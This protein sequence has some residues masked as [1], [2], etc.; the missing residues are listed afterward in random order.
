VHRDGQGNTKIQVVVD[1]PYTAGSFRSK[2]YECFFQWAEHLNNYHPNVIAV[3]FQINGY[4]PIRYQT[5][6]YD[7]RVS[8]LNIFS[9]EECQFLQDYQRLR[10]SPERFRPKELFSEMEDNQAQEVAACK[11]QSFEIENDRIRCTDGSALQALIPYVKRLLQLY[12]AI[13]EN[14]KSA[15][16]SHE[17]RSMSVEPQSSVF[18]E[19]FNQS[20][21][22]F[23]QDDLSLTEFLGSDQLQV[24]QVQMVDGEERTALNKV[25]QVLQEISCRSE[26]QYNILTL[27]PCL[28]ARE[29]MDLNISMLSIVTPYILLMACEA[30]QFLN[31]EAE[32]MLREIF[33]T[34]KDR[35]FIK[36]IMTSPSHDST[37]PRLQQIGREVFGNGF[38]TRNGELYF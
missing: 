25:Y 11:L 36:F 29:L 28:T 4:H 34:I 3:T 32:D 8:R 22:K 35:P 14:T 30:N 27:K 13:K 37:G 31:D 6:T 19:P 5:K 33:R 38:V 2:E 15:L 9:Q 12:P 20:V 23:K 16:S 17:F 10:R 1:W 24:L 21:L 7:E 18:L 26:V